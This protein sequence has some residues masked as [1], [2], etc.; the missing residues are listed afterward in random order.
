MDTV[1]VLGSGSWGTA[2]ATIVA[3]AG[4]QV[5]L[6]GRRAEQVER[7][8]TA[9]ENS[10]YLPG[11]KLAPSIVATTDPA[12]A[13]DGAEIVVV[14][15]P[16][17]K[18]RTTMTQWSNLVPSDAVLVSLM[19][20]IE[21]G[22]GL[23]MSQV[24]SQVGGF[25]AERIAVVSGPNLAGE[26]AARQPSASV[27]ASVSAATAEMVA[28]ACA[29]PFFRPYTDEDIVGVELGGATKNVIAVAVGVAEGMG[30]GDNTKATIVTR[31]LA[32][33]VRLGMALGAEAATFSGLAGV[34]DLIATCMS[35]LSRNHRVGVGLGQGMSL[36]EVV[37]KTGQ[38]AEGVASS[39]SILQLG[40]QLGVEMPITEAVVAVVHDGQRPQ[41][42]GDV[43]MSR[44]RKSEKPE[45]LRRP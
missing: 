24:I 19:K 14:A 21:R 25:E 43:L 20:G 30:L 13:L 22:T 34:G 4:A 5:R 28:D 10:D 38:T 15:L 39:L 31:G 23:R 11:V 32:E 3:D 7:I 41:L 18:M 35:P 9:H 27:V 45:Q 42:M 40:A 37:E 44:V 1:A 33:T 6:W 17:Q 29:T 12:E 36:D 16:S 8:N 2:F 26:I